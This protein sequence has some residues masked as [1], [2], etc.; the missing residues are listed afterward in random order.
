MLLGGAGQLGDTSVTLAPPK[1][2]ALVDRKEISRRP[3]LL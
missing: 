1:S 3:A 2:A